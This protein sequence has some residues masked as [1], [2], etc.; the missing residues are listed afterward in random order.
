[1]REKLYSFIT[2][3]IDLIERCAVFIMGLI[4][5]TYLGVCVFFYFYSSLFD[6]KIPKT[7]WDVFSGLSTIFS[8]I[9][10][11]WI[12][13]LTYRNQKSNAFQAEFDNLLKEH[14]KSLSE[15]FYEENKMFNF[16]ANYLLHKITNSNANMQYIAETYIYGREEISRYFILLYRILDRI[17]TTIPEKDKK[18]YTG[19]LRVCI[20]YEILLLVSINSLNPKFYRY[21]RLLEKY[22]MLEHL[23]LS[24]RFIID[25]RVKTAEYLLTKKKECT[26]PEFTFEYSYDANFEQDI[27]LKYDYLIKEDK[28]KNYLSNFKDS[29]FEKSIWGNNIHITRL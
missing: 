22:S 20:P 17:D 27:S 26:S 14:N 12:G 10:L 7:L 19:L 25:I 24:T 9:G 5:G 11:I 18:R 2:V 6:L 1:M 21:K 23:P 28:Y 13:F 4:L 3:L 15:N 16:H 29:L 8:A